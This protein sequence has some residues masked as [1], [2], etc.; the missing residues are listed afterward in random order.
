MKFVCR[1]HLAEFVIFSMVM[2]SLV[3]RFVL[4][5]SE[6]LWRQF[7]HLKRYSCVWFRT[8]VYFIFA[9]V[10]TRE[11]HFW[12]I[13]KRKYDDDNQ[14]IYN[15]LMAMFISPSQNSSLLAFTTSEMFL[16]YSLLMMLLLFVNFVEANFW[17]KNR[18]RLILMHGV[19]FLSYSLLQNGICVVLDFAWHWYATFF[20]E[21]SLWFKNW[22]CV[23]LLPGVPYLAY[24][25]FEN[26]SSLIIRNVL[27]VYFC[28]SEF[29]I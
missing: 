16:F 23:T 13:S 20:F 11:M 4:W 22:F 18:L 17:F 26:R 9:V 10:S 12:F 2:L 3:L 15:N 21:P 6:F 1:L 8:W 24:S 5:F 19:L 28:R 27:H 25:S 29:V 14:N 7:L